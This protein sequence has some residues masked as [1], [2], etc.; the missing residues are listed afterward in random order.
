MEIDYS[1]F[2]KVDIRAGTIIRAEEFPEAR[3][4][5][6]KIWVDFGP[7]IGERKS[8]AQVTHYYDLGD[9]VGK[10]VA[11]VINFPAKQIGPFM[12]E[13]LVLGF[14][15]EAGEVVLISPSHEVP[16]GGKLF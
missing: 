9:L 1:D 14:P 10:Q 7:E 2:S 11:A 8:S 15:N 6:Y 4:P 3:N 13:C 12:S 16:N 5:S